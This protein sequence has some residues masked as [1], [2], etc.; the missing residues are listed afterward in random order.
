MPRRT[1]HDVYLVHVQ[2]TLA[3]WNQIIFTLSGSTD[4]RVVP[5]ARTCIGVIVDDNIKDA[6]FDALIDAL[7]YIDSTDL[8][9]Q[10]KGNL[11][12]ESCQAAVSQVYS[13]LDE[14]IGLSKTNAMAPISSIPDEREVEAAKQILAAEG[15][16]DPLLD[17]TDPDNG[18][19]DEM[20]RMVESNIAGAPDDV[21][22]SS[23][24]E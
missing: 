24:I 4:P 3:K 18:P 22:G 2:N 11:V 14:Y 17:D 19:P 23:T 12:I 13:Y 8:N 7:D 5:Y 15:E 21:D 1:A 6:M 20:D 16:I 9:P 10:V